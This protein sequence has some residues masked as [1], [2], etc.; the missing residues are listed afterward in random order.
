MSHSHHQPITVNHHYHLPST[1]N[2]PNHAPW[3]I[4][5]NWTINGWTIHQPPN[6]RHHLS[7]INQPMNHSPSSPS[8]H[9]SLSN[10]H[11]GFAKHFR[12]NQPS[13]N[14]FRGYTCAASPGQ[15][16]VPPMSCCSTHAAL[17]HAARPTQLRISDKQLWP[18]M[19]RSHRFADRFINFGG[20]IFMGN[21]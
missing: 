11:Q 21:Q 12:M 14:I 13:P 10:F 2:E 7:N 20:T 17:L 16:N 8:I 18:R 1:I 19:K 6:I 5:Q 15:V 9:Q 4:N 3:P